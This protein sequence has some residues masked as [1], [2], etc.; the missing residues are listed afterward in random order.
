MI[1]I[2]IAIDKLDKIGLDKVKSEL[3]QRGLNEEQIS[4]IEKYLNINGAN[5]EKLKQI[6]ALLGHLDTRKKGIEELQ[7]VV[8]ALLH[9]PN[10]PLVLDFTLARRLNYYTGI[11]FE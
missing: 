8:N 9:T 7:F 5:E 10:S 3:A 2:T 1:D 6:E 4:T 11:I